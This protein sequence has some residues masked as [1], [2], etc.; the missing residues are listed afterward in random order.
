MKEAFSHMEVKA[1]TIFGLST[2]FSENL[3]N[4]PLW[5]LVR[6]LLELLPKSFHTQH[7]ISHK[8][9]WDL[10]SL[11]ISDPQFQITFL[12][13]NYKPTNFLQ[14]G[15]NW[16]STEVSPPFPAPTLSLCCVPAGVC[17]PPC[18]NGGR[19]V[20]PNV[21]DC[22]SGWRGKHCSKR[23]HLCSHQTVIIN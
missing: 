19:C 15:S 20:H 23:K 11:C 5:G 9:L 18:M 14:G 17:D 21:C 2:C 12:V 4:Q 3:C 13:F 16:A 6:Q 22:P 8:D 7:S 10:S 1:L